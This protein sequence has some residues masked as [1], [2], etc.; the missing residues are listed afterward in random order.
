MRRPPAVAGLFHPAQLQALETEVVRLLSSRQEPQPVKAV[1][2]P[3]P[4]IGYSGVVTGAVYRRMR[5]PAGFLRFGPNHRG[6][7]EPVAMMAE[8]EWETPL[9]AVAID[10]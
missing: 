8:G 1:V 2:S 6:V 7:G 5:C 10:H 4:G 9:G 3:H